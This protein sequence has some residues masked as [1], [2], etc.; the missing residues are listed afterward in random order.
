MHFSDRGSEIRDVLASALVGDVAIAPY[1][2]GVGAPSASLVLSLLE[3]VQ[4][5]PLSSNDA[6]LRPELLDV[7]RA[8]SLLVEETGTTEMRLHRRI[9]PVVLQMRITQRMVVRQSQRT[10]RHVKLLCLH[11]LFRFDFNSLRLFYSSPVIE[12]ISYT[13]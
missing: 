7:Y 4:P 6:L 2:L 11:R 8:A 1:L 5:L 10:R 3:S 9:A 12:G 13:I